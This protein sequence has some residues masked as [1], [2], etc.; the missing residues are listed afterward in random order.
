MTPL[1]DD[2]SRLAAKF[3]P[4]AKSIALRMGRG[5]D[6]VFEAAYY[7]VVVGVKQWNAERSNLTY[8]VKYRVVHQILDCFRDTRKQ[9]SRTASLD[10]WFHFERSFGPCDRNENKHFSKVRDVM[11]LALAAKDEPVGSDIEM[12]DEVEWKLRQLP[13]KMAEA[14]RLCYL[15]GVSQAQAARVMN[16]SQTEV[17][18]QIKLARELAQGIA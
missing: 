14:V 4:L 3:V 5:N 12:R 6:D 8:A 15:E 18:R 16:C 13:A 10:S 17:S 2:Q 11:E 9:R 1:T 7:G